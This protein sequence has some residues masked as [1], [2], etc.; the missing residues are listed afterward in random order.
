MSPNLGVSLLVLNIAACD[1]D[2]D[3]DEPRAVEHTKPLLVKDSVPGEL[4]E[5]A[6]PQVEDLK[7]QKRVSELDQA[8]SSP[9]LYMKAVEAAS[10]LTDEATEVV[11]CQGGEIKVSAHRYKDGDKLVKS[12]LEF[13]AAGHRSWSYHAY[14]RGG[15]L[16]TVRHQIKSWSFAGGSAD[17]PETRDTVLERIYQVG[18][19]ETVQCLERRAA[20]PTGQIEELLAQAPLK[21]IDCDSADAPRILQ[22]VEKL[23]GELDQSSL[24]KICQSRDPSSGMGL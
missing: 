8:P 6:L 11:E 24:E 21:T 22:L 3:H 15:S 19:D 7:E 12:S 4:N 20:G 23:Q 17:Q 14:M 5:P 18:G 9:L 10:Q 1:R 13:A 2:R 16:M